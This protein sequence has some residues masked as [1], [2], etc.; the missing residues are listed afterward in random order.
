MEDDGSLDRPLA[1]RPI[2]EGEEVEAHGVHVKY[3]T[4][5][6]TGDTQ[7]ASWLDDENRQPI[8]DRKEYPRSGGVGKREA[9]HLLD[10]ETNQGIALALH[11]LTS[12]VV[13]WFGITIMD[14]DQLEKG[15]PEDWTK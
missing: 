14:L 13:G 3:T 6:I 7:I 8:S 11:P 1:V 2:K 10:P 12:Q 5:P 15:V 9:I 4:H